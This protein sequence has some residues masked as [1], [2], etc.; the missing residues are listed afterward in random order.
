MGEGESQCEWAE[1][2]VKKKGVYG[3]S[4][5]KLDNVFNIF[6]WHFIETLYIT[7][8]VTE[9]IEAFYCWKF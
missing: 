7:I 8:K 5:R 2:T 6:Y 3:K 4:I 9:T 1:C